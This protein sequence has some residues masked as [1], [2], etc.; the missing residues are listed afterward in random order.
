MS[1]RRTNNIAALLAGFGTGY[2]QT[3]QQKREQERQAKKDKSEEEDR[4]LRRDEIALQKQREADALA[5]FDAASKMKVGELR[6]E[7][8]AVDNSEAA[9]RE[10][11]ATTPDNEGNL[12]TAEV[13]AATA[14]IYAQEAAKKGSEKWL[15]SS[16][17]N[18]ILGEVK[19]TSRG[20][21]KRTEAAAMAKLGINGLPQ[22]MAMKEKADE[23]DIKDL[24]TKILSATTIEE[25]NENYKI[26]P[27][28]YDLKGEADP[29]TGR[30]K[31]WYESESGKKHFPDKAMPQDFAD[32]E[33]M[34]KFASAFVSGNPEYIMTQYENSRK[35][36]REDKKDA[37]EEKV[38]AA[39]LAK[40]EQ[41]IAEGKIK[42]ASLPESI[43]LDI[44]AKK[45][46]IAQSYAAAENSKASAD[47][48]KAEAKGGAS[49]DKLPN[50]VREALWY[51]E[52]TPEQKKAFDS[53]NDKTPKVTSDGMGGF[54]IN[55]KD[56]MYRMDGAGKMTK[57]TL[58]DGAA[59]VQ[60]P[61][62][63]TYE[64]LYK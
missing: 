62:K 7:Q 14:P 29:T 30:L 34:K 50:S 25:L 41:D 61:K 49:N 45:A 53:M 19:P 27:D 23:L 39:Q 9:W 55:N 46:N 13:A 21:I 22:A 44:K 24:Q 28:G 59:P 5:G 2:L 20:D 47:K 36:K 35:T 60:P 40:Y 16:A 48:T 56:G 18:A 63:T 31:Y 37:R 17:A 32:F 51:Q 8:G 4:Q 43:Q 38:S 6:N 57:V 42:L 52:A 64:S 33:E 26:F 58:P 11:I 54:V 1:R 3:E 12:P 15:S 10:R